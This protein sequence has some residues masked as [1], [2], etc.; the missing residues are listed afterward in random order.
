MEPFT[1]AKH[2]MATRFEVV[3][4]GNG[5]DPARL[6]AAA[7]MV[8]RE[9]ERVEAQLSFY[10]D[11]SEI[12]R[13]NRYAAIE[14]VRVSSPVF[15][16]LE[17]AQGLARE[18]GGAFDISIAPLMQCWGFTKGSGAFPS[19]EAI[20]E[21][22]QKCGMNRVHLDPGARTVSFETAGMLL[23]L[24]GIGK[25][26][27]LDLATEVLQ[28]AGITSALIHGGTSTA[29][30]IGAPPNADSWT[31]ALAPP[32]EDEQGLPQEAKEEVAVPLKNEALSV[33]AGSGKAF[34]HEGKSYGHVLDPRTGWPVE[35]ALTAAVILP[36]ATEADALSTALL[37]MSKQE[38]LAL[39]KKRSS[40]RWR[41][42]WKEG[43]GERLAKEN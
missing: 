9:I 13:I 35:G 5:E 28:E 39:A 4:Y 10:S 40:I 34:V 43:V 3:L 14:P 26:Y 36:S 12:R 24:G 8:F 2:A 25:G 1:A 30:A 27:A 22:Q 17:R 6:H 41:V 42:I 32:P 38:A 20:E 33:S 37:T 31:I 21:A 7:D 16:L 23:D 18:T 11:T 15:R 19:S 29:V